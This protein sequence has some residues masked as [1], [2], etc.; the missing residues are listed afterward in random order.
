MFFRNGFDPHNPGAAPMKVRCPACNKSAVFPE[1]E[2]GMPAVC[3]ACGERYIVPA[4]EPVPMADP[5]RV[6]DKVDSPRT[7]FWTGA[8]MWIGAA[9]AAA[10]IG[11]ALGLWLVDRLDRSRR[12]SELAQAVRLKDEAQ[13]LADSGRLREAH[14]K[15]LDLGA[16]ASTHLKDSDAMRQ[17]AGVA[18]QK[19]QRVYQALLARP[20]PAAPLPQPPPPAT[21]PS[22]SAAIVAHAALPPSQ[23]ATEITPAP[24]PAPPP[25]I[26][27]A[28]IQPVVEESSELSDKQIGTAIEHGVNFLLP[29]FNRLTHQ[30]RADIQGSDAHREGADILSVY[31]LMQCGRAINDPRLSLHGPLMRGLIDAMKALPLQ[32]YHY[33]T[34]ARAL[35]ATALSLSDRPDD[36]AAMKADATW[37]VMTTNNGAYTYNGHDLFQKN[38]GVGSDMWDNSNSQYGLLGVWSAAEVGFEVASKYWELVQKHWTACQSIDGQWAYSGYWRRSSGSLSMTCAGLSSLFVTHDYLDAPKLGSIVGREPFTPPLRAGLQWLEEDDHCLQYQSGGWPGYTLY[39]IERVGLA[40]GFK[41]FGS[42]DWYRELASR[43]LLTQSDD[44]SWHQDVVDTAYH[45]LFLSRG[46]HPIVMNKLRFD[47]YWANR[48]RDVANL[49]RFASRQLERPLNWQVVPLDHDFTD[50]MDSPILYLASH[51]APRFSERDYEQLRNFVAAGGMIFTQSDADSPEFSQFVHDLSH[52]LFPLYE[53]QDVPA[54]HPLYNVLYKINMNPPLRM[55]SNGSQILLLHSPTDLS[56]YWQARDEKHRSGPFEFG[57]NLFIYAAGKRDLR[58]RLETT[59]IAPVTQSPVQTVRVA[60]LKYAGNWDPEPGAWPRYQRWFQRQT[61]YVLDV[62]D[63]AIKELRP[64]TAPVAHL[65]GTSR[66]SP[67]PAEV[68][69]IKRYVL[70]GGVLLVDVTG[71]GNG[72]G[73]QLQSDLFRAAF[74]D[75]SSRVIYPNHPLLSPGGSGMED[76]G[77]PR[78]RQYAVDLLGTRAGLPEEIAA[79]RGHVLFT[80]LDLTSGLL[81]TNTWGILG[82]ESNY[83]QDLLKNVVFWTLDGQ[84]DEQDVARSGS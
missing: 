56:K 37:L 41:Y 5:P 35:R 67:T 75:Q 55:V 27:R 47:G 60:R 51:R 2:A 46:R 15:Y 84:R 66:Y 64:E 77:R 39:G 30:L 3:A 82:Y 10:C 8:P 71:G 62:R 59:Y 44:G 38:H 63:I 21:G 22:P 24:E 29:A 23:S 76:L 79:G 36:R 57:I 12:A 49:A 25:R 4:P 45:L 40:S 52:H 54:N 28:P 50:W 70:S 33:A 48:P 61:G 20:T 31:A 58:N 19:G 69:A 17:L 42:H 53:M 7:S 74:P 65:T 68:E 81:G 72:F 18:R 1:S 80:S 9:V 34:Y 73:E 6:A 16:L 11:M 13:S 83:A 43:I 78:L 26:P 14:E 32:D